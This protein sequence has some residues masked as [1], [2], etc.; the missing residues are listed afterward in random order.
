MNELKDGMT[1]LQQKLE[2][3]RQGKRPA[4]VDVS[5]EVEPEQIKPE[6]PKVGLE[7]PPSSGARADQR[8]MTNAGATREHVVNFAQSMMG[9]I[10]RSSN[11]MAMQRT[12]AQ[13]QLRHPWA[14]MGPMQLQQTAASATGPTAADRTNAAMA[15]SSSSATG[16]P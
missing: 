8:F 4:A 16:V 14:L 9:N 12:A 7:R 5:T 11:T 2:D 13:G 1:T 10:F 15:S 3:E 6:V